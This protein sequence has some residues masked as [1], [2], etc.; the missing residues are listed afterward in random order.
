[1]SLHAGE[2]LVGE[3]AGISTTSSTPSLPD[4]FGTFERLDHVLLDYL[5]LLSTELAQELVAFVLGQPPIPVPPLPSSALYQASNGLASLPILEFALWGGLRY[6]NVDYAVSGLTL[7]GDDSALFFGSS[8]GDQFRT[9]ALEGPLGTASQSAIQWSL[10]ASGAA[11]LGD[12]TLVLA[13]TSTLGR[14]WSAA[15]NGSMAG[16]EVW[17][18]LGGV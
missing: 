6:A 13:T 16:A 17:S 5:S 3:I 15:G 14:V 10:T 1:M 11:A 4:R 9:W 7:P 18:E 8:A 12:G 2:L